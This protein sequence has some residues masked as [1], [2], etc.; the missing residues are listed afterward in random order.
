MVA[1]AIPDGGDER[2]QVKATPVFFIV[3][4]NPINR[5]AVVRLNSVIVGLLPLVLTAMHG[6]LR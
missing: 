5:N 4:Q 6:L 1:I 2:G 3:V